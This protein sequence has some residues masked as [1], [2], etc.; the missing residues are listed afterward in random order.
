MEL[1]E[2]KI[3]ILTSST[4]GGHDSAAAAVRCA[5]EEKGALCEVRDFLDFL[6]KAKRT[7]LAGGHVFLYRHAPWL[8][9]LGYRFEEMFPKNLYTDY[10][11]Y[12]HPLGCY[13]ISRGFDAVICV[14][15]FPVL[16]LTAAKR[17]YGYD[18]PAYFI[19]TDYTSSPGAGQM[20]AE[21]LFVPKGCREEFKKAYAGTE[22]PFIAETGIPVAKA[23]GKPVEKA[24]AMRKLGIPAGRKLVLVSAGSMGCGPL[25]RTAADLAEARPDVMVAVFT[26][27]N[28]KMF[29]QMEEKS[30]ALPNL[31]PVS[32]TKEMPLWMHAAD[33][34]IS[35]PGGLSSTEAATA[36]LPLLLFDEVPGLE[37]HNMAYFVKRGCAAREKTAERLI[38]R[39]SLM[40]D[41]DEELAGIRK[42]QK[43]LFSE[44]AA[45]QIISLLF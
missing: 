42:R 7:M 20:E 6:P 1:K 13:V 8:F 5:L 16:M 24:E 44:D 41:N 28:K 12:A 40:L 4:G 26:G 25:L 19:S 2:K 35:K 11:G 3:L 15:I 33:L 27:S 23:F 38:R 39:A 45:E 37:T 36:G 18:V 22:L 9:A 30:R 17:K 14:H 29:R 10:A 34:M 31:L 21:K 32:F 43:K